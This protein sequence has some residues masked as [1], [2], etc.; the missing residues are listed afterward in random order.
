M[1][2]EDHR[3]DADFESDFMFLCAADDT[4][5]PRFMERFALTPNSTAFE[6]YD[7]ESDKMLHETDKIDGLL[8]W[9]RDHPL[10]PYTLY[11]ASPSGGAFMW[12]QVEGQQVF[13]IPYNL[14]G[15]ADLLA[16]LKDVGATA[17]WGSVHVPPPDTIAEINAELAAKHSYFLRYKDGALIAASES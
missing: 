4:L 14:L 12:A 16:L 3:S 17:G 10:A 15:P 2:I 6:V 7:Y 8:S 5:L 11:L 13:S 1:T 9:L